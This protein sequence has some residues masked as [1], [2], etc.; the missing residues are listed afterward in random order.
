MVLEIEGVVYVVEPPNNK[1]PSGSASY[2]STVTPDA[3]DAFKVTIPAAVR[4]LLVTVGAAGNALTVTL[5]ILLK[6]VVV[7]PLMVTEAFLLK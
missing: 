6:P 3:T 2:Q 4:A 5:M 1:L 7:V